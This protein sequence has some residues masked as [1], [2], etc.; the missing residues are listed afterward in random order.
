LRNFSPLGRNFKHPAILKGEGGGEM[1]KNY[2]A[3]GLISLLI[4]ALAVPAG[5]QDRSGMSGGQSNQGDQYGRKDQAPV[6][7][8]SGDEQKQ[9]Q[10]EPW[11]A[12]FY[13][14]SDKLLNAKVKDRNGKDAG[15]VSNLILDGSGKVAYVI[16]SHG[17]F[18]GMGSRKISVPAGAVTVSGTGDQRTLTLNFDNEHINSSPEF[19]SLADLNDRVYAET[20]YRFFGLQPG[21]GEEAGRSMQSRGAGGSADQYQLQFQE[22]PLEQESHK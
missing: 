21:W 10:R 16:I 6:Q 22:R 5:A 2:L 18:A 7:T 15:S 4:V 11:A 19:N 1:W 13:I 17:G 14:G 12:F 20:I 3:A 8:Q 9:P